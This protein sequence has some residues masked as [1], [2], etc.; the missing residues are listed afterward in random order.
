MFQ[1]VL[2]TDTRSHRC[3]S[4]CEYPC[5]GAPQFDECAD[6]YDADAFAGTAYVSALLKPATAHSSGDEAGRSAALCCQCPPVSATTTAM[7]FPV[8]DADISRGCV[9]PTCG[10]SDSGGSAYACGWGMQAVAANSDVPLTFA[11]DDTD[12]QACCECQASF[13]TIYESGQMRCVELTCEADSVVGGTLQPYPCST[14]GSVS[15]TLT[16]NRATG[17]GTRTDALCCECVL[18]SPATRRPLG[19]DTMEGGR[20]MAP[21]LETVLKTLPDNIIL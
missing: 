11:E 15:A 8:D 18:P 16:N 2:V 4:R 21:R 1:G 5:G 10:Y 19:L 14:A 3:I 17:G 20:N 9:V 7:T 13:G 6:G 12:T